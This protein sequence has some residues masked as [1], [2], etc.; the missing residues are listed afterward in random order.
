MENF[1]KIQGQEIYSVLLNAKNI[2][3]KELASVIEKIDNAKVTVRYWIFF[4][5][6]ISLKDNYFRRCGYFSDWRWEKGQLAE[7]VGAISRRERRVV[8]LKDIYEI[9]KNELGA[10][11]NH[12]GECYLTKDSFSCLDNLR[13]RTK[14]LND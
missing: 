2:L 14:K 6:E 3:D 12:S 5:K 9:L 8:E 1:I 11:P 7:E 10:I 13:D 4:K